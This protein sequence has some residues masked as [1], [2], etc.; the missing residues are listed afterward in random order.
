MKNNEDGYKILSSTFKGGGLGYTYE[1]TF[2]KSLEHTGRFKGI[3]DGLDAYVK[4]ELSQNLTDSVIG[5][6][7]AFIVWVKSKL[8]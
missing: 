7:T 6:W 5:V 3:E 8:K 4:K 2:N 1:L